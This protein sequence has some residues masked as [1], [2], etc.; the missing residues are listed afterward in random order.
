M[1]DLLVVG[2]GPAGLATSLYAARAGL[3]AVIVEQRPGTLDKACGEGMMPHAL[4]HLDR[5]GVV[6]TGRTLRG[7]SYHAGATRV[8]AAFRGGVGRGVRRTTLHAAMSDAARAAGVKF[9][10]GTAGE[11]TQDANSVRAGQFRARYVVAADGLHSPIRRDLGLSRPAAGPRRWGIRRH[12]QMAPWTDHVE[13]H[14]SRE[15]EAYVTPVA[16]D[17]VGIAILSAGRGGFESKFAAFD[18]L[19]QRVAGHEFGPA[20]A[21]GPLRQQV[22]NRVAGRVLLVGDAAGYVDAL[23]GEGM[24][25]AFSA[26]EALVDCV[27]RD[28]VDEYDHRWRALTR[29]YRL[30]TEALVQ[31]GAVPA[32]RSRVVPAAAALPKVFSAA[33]NLLAN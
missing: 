33:V 16:D 31:A 22:R 25:L 8:E 11:I 24:G 13:V 14:W 30:L 32:L 27:V 26:A 6:T 21:A 10:L 20:R 29:R 4:A 19:R 28:R 17:C 1:I 18:E 2:G 7:I 15:A 9:V 23:T 12:V 5:L 3:E